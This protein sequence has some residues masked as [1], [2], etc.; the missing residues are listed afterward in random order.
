MATPATIIDRKLPSIALVGR[1]NVG[2]STLFNLIIAQQKAI[3][4]Q[5]PGTTRTRNIG[6]ANWRGKNFYLVDTGGLTFSESIPL[7]D[8]IIKQTE[9]AIKEADLILFVVDI[10]TGI[11]PQERELAKRL[12]KNKDRVIFVANKA[13]SE[14]FRANIYDRE[15]MA[16]GFGEPFPV[17]AA[18]GSNVG[19]L[20][21]QIYKKL[22][23]NKQKRT[24]K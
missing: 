22:P 14:K 15:L 9:L 20:L 24:P 5:I 23:K 12:I 7:E 11:L 2:K 17:S 3:V 10:Q 21:D 4:S 6:F 19:N 1:V 18:N 8:E 13:D 16:L